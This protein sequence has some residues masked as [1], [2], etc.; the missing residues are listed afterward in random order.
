MKTGDKVGAFSEA[1]GIWLA[2]TV[3]SLEPA[4]IVVT[5][6]G[7]AGPLEWNYP[8]NLVRPLEDLR[9]EGVEV[10]PEWEGEQMA[11][12]TEVRELMK[13]AVIFN[14]HTQ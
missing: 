5:H 10:L 13:K 9:A 7:W 12:N 8:D 1:D 11:D 6:V 2:G 14:E 3:F 4:A